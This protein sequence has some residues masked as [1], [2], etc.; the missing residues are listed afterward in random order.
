MYRGLFPS[1]TLTDQNNLKGLLDGQNLKEDREHQKCDWWTEMS[2]FYPP[3]FSQKPY[4]SGA[5]TVHTT[6]YDSCRWKMLHKHRDP[7]NSNG[8]GSLSLYKAKSEIN[9]VKPD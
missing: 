8:G 9:Q 7:L 6:N 1:H 5:T 2:P 4:V 3:C